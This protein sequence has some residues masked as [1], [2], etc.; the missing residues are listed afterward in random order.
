MRLRQLARK[1]DIKPEAIL[2]YVQKNFGL[3]LTDEPNL[4]LEEE[5]VAAITEHYTP[6][7]VV[8]EPP[9]ES[10]VEAPEVVASAVVETS[11]V[12]TEEVAPEAV[13]SDVVAETE[14]NAG[15]LVETDT[16]V[17]ED[18][19]V[20]TD[21]TPENDAI[22]SDTAVAENDESVTESEVDFD[23][24]VIKAPIVQLPGPK[25]IGKIDLPDTSEQAMPQ[26]EIDGVM[27]DKR[28]GR[29]RR[30][31]KRKTKP[32]IEE[33]TFNAPKRRSR[34][35]DEATK[36]ER[37]KFKSEKDLQRE[38]AERRK[39]EQERIKRKK[40]KKRE[41]YQK[42]HQQKPTK[43]KNA[44]KKEQAKKAAAQK[45]ALVKEAPK[46][47]LAKLWHWLNNG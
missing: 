46:G 26:V 24:D 15:E 35:V 12:P 25:V 10:P 28:P 13:D 11:E 19:V 3:E 36:K 9:I 47:G 44:P 18:E 34:V 16:D 30:N 14:E 20:A 4:K 27:Y 6:D 41:H 33:G 31:T 5:H 23:A 40:E 38:E 7:P 22:V 17:A 29:G 21:E 8:V 45:A 1:L 2:N 42:N 39:K 37:A 32:G 43:K